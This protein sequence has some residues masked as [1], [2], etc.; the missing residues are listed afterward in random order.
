[1]PVIVETQTDA[2]AHNLSD[3]SFSPPADSVRRP[4][5]G[6]EIKND[7][8]ATI[9]VIGSDGYTRPLVDAGGSLPPSSD[10]AVAGSKVRTKV[11]RNAMN[12]SYFYS[13]FI[14]QSVKDSRQEK[15][16]FMETFG[17]TYI[18]FF[19]ERPES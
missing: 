13:N 9:Q 4:F 1:M 3:K 17:D 8:Y 10:N 5:R 19:G 2:F 14:I 11:S 12:S 6:I 18:F 16:Q 7:T 15:A